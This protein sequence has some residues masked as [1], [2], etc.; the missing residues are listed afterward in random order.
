MN[1]TTEKGRLTM[2][3][4]T[5]LEFQ[6]DMEFVLYYPECK[7]PFK[8][9]LNEITGKTELVCPNCYHKIPFKATAQ[10]KRMIKGV[11]ALRELIASKDL[12]K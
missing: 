10:T 4:D 2:I 7:I 6:Q 12:L 5:D 1:N 9:K 3:N 11:N 8:R